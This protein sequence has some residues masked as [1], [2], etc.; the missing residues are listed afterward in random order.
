VARLFVT[1][2]ELDLI[3]DL[4]QEIIKDVVGQKVYYYKVRKDLSNVHDVY[5]EAEE[6]VFNPPVEICARVEWQQANFSTTKF[7][8]DQNSTI[9]VWL[10]YRDV[11]F[12][13]LD[14]AAG[15]YVSYGDTFF[16]ILSA[17]L[18][19]TIYGQIEYSTGYVMNCKQARKGLI[20]KIPHGPTDESYS[21]EDA[22]Q[23]VFVQQRGFEENRL[24]PTGDNRALIDQ[25]VLDLPVS[26]EPAEVSPR[27]SPARI[28][29]SFYADEG[30]KE[31]C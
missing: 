3:S 29:S 12:K 23:K 1:P 15:D 27:G 20:D 31:D 4:S 10:Q 22:T 25:G 16:E 14:V 28:G 2:R 13:Q 18:D 21:D 17:K 8:I 30:I 24:G 7:G 5:E 11:M 9:T 26:N 6:K 19:S